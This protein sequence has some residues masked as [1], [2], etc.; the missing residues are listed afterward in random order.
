[1]IL[2]AQ[3]AIAAR[4]ADTLVIDDDGVRIGAETVPWQDLVA[5]VVSVGAKGRPVTFLPRLDE[6]MPSYEPSYPVEVEGR[7]DWVPDLDSRTGSSFRLRLWHRWRASRWAK[8]IM[9]AVAVRRPEIPIHDER[10][11]GTW[12]GPLVPGDARTLL[13]DVSLGQGARALAPAEAEAGRWSR[14]MM[15]KRDSRWNWR[16]FSLIAGALAICWLALA[17]G[18]SDQFVVVPG[19]V[20]AHSRQENGILQPV[21]HYQTR[22]GQAMEIRPPIAAGE[23]RF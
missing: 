13:V 19:T 4:T 5:V 16:R 17:L 22:S 21:V 15:P 12:N 8:E 7:A 10:R 2:L 20:V 3:Q 9:H 14:S 1:V 11:D 6:R 18:G 23:E